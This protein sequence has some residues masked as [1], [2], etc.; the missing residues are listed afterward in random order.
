MFLSVYLRIKINNLLYT[1]M[2]WLKPKQLKANVIRRW[3]D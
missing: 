2:L 3:N 1:T